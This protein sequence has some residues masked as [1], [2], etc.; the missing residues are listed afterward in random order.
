MGRMALIIVLGLTVTV[1]IIS[2]SLNKAKTGTVENVAGFHKYATAR[3]IAHTSINMALRALDRNDSV[4]LAT[5]SM[6][7]STMGGS[8]SLTFSYPNVSSLDTIDMQTTATYMD[9]VKSMSIRLYRTPVPFP[10]IGEGVG[11]HVDS[12]NFD[13]DGASRIDGHNH[14]VDGNLLP[15]SSDDKPG[16]GVI[17]AGDTTTVLRDASKI[18]GTRDVV[19]DSAMSDPGLYV[20]EYINAADRV[21][22][23][24]TTIGGSQVWGSQSAPW[25]VYCDGTAGLVKFDGNIVGWGILVVKGNLTFT[26]TF[27]FHGIMIASND[28]QVDVSFSSGTP[29]IIGGVLMSGAKG[30]EFFMKGNSKIDYSKDALN[31]AKF[32]NKLQVYRVMRWFE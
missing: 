1:G 21:F 28:V 17:R 16:V 7:V 31:L 18:D 12:V 5:K 20:D 13:M 27:Q 10:V 2:F 23:G 24:P 9:S 22:T 25:I 14:D 8:A 6:N 26:G 3:D 15:P 4:F 29:N 19:V 32:I 30:S 11:L